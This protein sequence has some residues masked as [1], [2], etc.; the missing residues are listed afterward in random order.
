MELDGEKPDDGTTRI[1]G[2]FFAHAASSIPQTKLP[3]AVVG[4]TFSIV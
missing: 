4:C 3:Y 2:S 1:P